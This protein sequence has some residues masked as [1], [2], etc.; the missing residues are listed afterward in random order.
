MSSEDPM[1]W[2]TPEP[3]I[4]PTGKVRERVI[5]GIIILLGL[6]AISSLLSVNLFPV[7]TNDSLTYIGFG[8][9]L[10]EFGF[11][12][13]GYR[14][15]GYPLF[16]WITESIST[17]VL[18]IEP[19]LFVSFTQR[20]LLVVGMGYAI[21]FWRW[22]ALPVVAVALTAEILSYT[23]LILSEGLSVPLALILVCATSHFL[24][25]ANRNEPDGVR[26]TGLVLGV[27][28][29]LIALWLLAIRFTFAVFGISPLVI[30]IAA[31]NTVFRRDVLLLFGAYL[32]G[33]TMIVGLTSAENKAE[34]GEFSPAT[35]DARTAYWAAWSTTFLLDPSN[36][37]D[38]DLAELY[39]NGTPYEFIYEVDALDV[40]YP[41]QALI[42]RKAIEEMLVTAGTGVWGSRVQSFLGALRA[43][44][45]N[46]IAGVVG[47]IV[48]SDKA[49]IDS[50]IHANYYADQFGPEAFADDFNGGQLPEAVITAP[51]AERFPLPSAYRLVGFLLPLSL[52]ACCV[53]LVSRDARLLSVAGLAVVLAYSALIGYIRADSF[54]LLLTTG[55]FGIGAGVGAL[56]MWHAQRGR[57]APIELGPGRT[58]LAP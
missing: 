12:H 44:R 17:S 41:E 30:A 6:I 32:F 58:E 36:A 46:D 1:T 34:Y 56:A 5:L 15:F 50:A 13:L 49:S 26:T 57:T 19:L 33:A 47:T 7:I 9:N 18:S 28:V 54:R 10:G 40:S 51:L 25:V 2:P 35:R 22:W 29:V 45:L 42:Y 21:W 37:S 24:C 27:G 38:P 14:Q 20:L 8:R 39:G 16:L 31:R 48:S 52:L 3:S 53:T 23:N 4:D 11:V 55:I 43:G